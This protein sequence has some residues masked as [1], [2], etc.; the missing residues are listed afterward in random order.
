[1]HASRVF[2][3]GEGAVDGLVAALENIVRP[4]RRTG[5]GALCRADTCGQ[6]PPPT[7]SFFAGR[8]GG[9]GGGGATPTQMSAYMSTRMYMHAPAHA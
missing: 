7:P 4:E 1:M 6:A 5:L 8:W 2:V 3:P 9:G